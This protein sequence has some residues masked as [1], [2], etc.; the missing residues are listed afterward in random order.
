M[1]QKNKHAVRMIYQQVYDAFIEANMN[2][3]IHLQIHV[4]IPVYTVHTVYTPRSSKTP[5]FSYRATVHQLASL[6]HEAVE[7]FLRLM[8]LSWML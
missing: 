4:S 8:E 1:Q 2:A 3:C 6:V 7:A 5:Q